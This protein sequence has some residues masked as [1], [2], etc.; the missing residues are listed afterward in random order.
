MGVGEANLEDVAQEVFMVVHKR[1]H[2]YDGTSLMT[3]W[4]YGIC[5][6]VAAAWRRRA[7][8]R[9]EQPVEQPPERPSRPEISGDEWMA[10][11][12]AQRRLRAVLDHMDLDKRAVLVAFDIE[13]LSSEE[14]ATML[15]V[16]VGTV[17]SRLH[18]ARKQFE[19][20]LARLDARAFR[21]G[22]R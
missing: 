21:G 15:G 10:V 1:L 3:T 4:L 22:V 12:Q 18:G 11:Q 8:F 2:T 16:P 6:R 20:I 14:I 9:R 19:E 17:W 5:L 7:W 13:E